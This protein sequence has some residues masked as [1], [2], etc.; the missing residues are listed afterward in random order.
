MFSFPRNFFNMLAS[1]P[2]SEGGG[3]SRDGRSACAA[4]AAGFKMVHYLVPTSWTWSVSTEYRYFGER[5][6]ERSSS[7]MESLWR[8]LRDWSQQGRVKEGR[9]GPCAS[10]EGKV[11][12]YCDIIVCYDM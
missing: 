8:R 1:L 11:P 3:G 4:I 10:R 9:A 6:Q 12:G 2:V 7:G 5:K